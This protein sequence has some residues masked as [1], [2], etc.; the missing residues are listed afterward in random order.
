[1]ETQDWKWKGEN[2]HTITYR[3]E[4]YGEVVINKDLH[5]YLSKDFNKRA[6]EEIGELPKEWLESKDEFVRGMA[7][8]K[9]LEIKEYMEAG[10]TKEQAEFLQYKLSLYLKKF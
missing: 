1:M 7:Y 3:C 6:I 5:N 10:F 4:K 2:E 9:R 8:R